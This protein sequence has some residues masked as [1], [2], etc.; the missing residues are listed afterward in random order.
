MD[1]LD[2]DLPPYLRLERPVDGTERSLSKRLEES[3]SPKVLASELQRG[4][5]FEDLL[6]DVLELGRGIDPE[7]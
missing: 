7:L 3:V 6:L 1:D 2:R 4:I 5:L